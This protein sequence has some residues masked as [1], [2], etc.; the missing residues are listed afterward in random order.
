VRARFTWPLA[1]I[2]M[3]D[4]RFALTPRGPLKLLLR[5]TV[6]RYSETTEIKTLPSRLASMIEFRSTRPDVDGAFFVTMNSNFA[7]LV[8]LFRSHGVSIN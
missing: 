7:E 3:E 4:D 6:V 5:P 8:N 1:K 2:E